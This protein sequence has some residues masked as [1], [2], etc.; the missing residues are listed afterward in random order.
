MA[1]HETQVSGQEALG[2]HDHPGSSSGSS[3]E[4]TAYDRGSW[5]AAHTSHTDEHR[6]N[7]PESQI[8]STTML[9]SKDKDASLGARAAQEEESPSRWTRLVCNTWFFES[10]AISFSA[11]CL[12]AIVVVLLVY[13]NKGLN[14][15]PYD[16]T[17]NAIVSTLATGAKASLLCAVAGSIGQLKWCWF[18]DKRKLY[19]LQVFDD[20]SRGP[21]GSISLLVGRTGSILALIGAAL[22]VLALVFDPFI[23]QVIKYPTRSIIVPEGT[24]QTRKASGF[25]ANA[26]STDF[27]SAINSGLWS[28]ATQFNRTPICSSGDCEWPSFKSLGWCSKCGD[29]TSQAVV[30]GNCRERVHWRRANCALSLRT[31]S[32]VT[33]VTPDPKTYE[34][35]N[36]AIN[37]LSEVMWIVQHMR[38]DRHRRRLSS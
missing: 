22:T 25:P 15:M 12:I 16:I 9:L 4:D 26:Y 31:G 19:D 20:A 24:A 10:L 35:D 30:R 8:T 38:H 28:D 17:L 23:Q 33:I 3:R 1:L 34:A 6:R 7:A 14:P 27:M 18:Q 21:A 32:N 2:V 29:A 36:F 37:T 11:L 5:Q 13:H